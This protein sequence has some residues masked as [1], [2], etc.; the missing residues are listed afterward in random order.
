MVRLSVLKN[1][2]FFFNHTSTSAKFIPGNLVPKILQGLYFSNF[3]IPDWF[4]FPP[5]FSLRL[6]LVPSRCLRR[7]E[8]SKNTNLSKE[9]FF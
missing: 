4:L 8:E 6:L 2:Y 1:I 3:I 7:L 9:I 5:V